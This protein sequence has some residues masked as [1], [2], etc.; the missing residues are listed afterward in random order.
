MEPM[1][2]QQVGPRWGQQQRRRLGRRLG[3]RFEQQR[4]L[5][6]VDGGSSTPA[7][8][9]GTI[10]VGVDHV[11]RVFRV[12]DARFGTGRR[13]RRW[14]RRVRRRQRLLGWFGFRWV[15]LVGYICG[16]SKIP[17]LWVG[18]GDSKSHFM[19]FQVVLCFLFKFKELFFDS[20]L[21]TVT[22]H[23]GRNSSEL[24]TIKSTFKSRFFLYSF[25]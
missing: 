16:K 8:A 12:V 21:R 20:F 18:I 3:R 6:G 25:N 14:R 19:A 23:I 24:W 1:W 22:L 11:V 17:Y 2:L 9:A 15:K 13:R 4:G 10:Y 5:D 7:A